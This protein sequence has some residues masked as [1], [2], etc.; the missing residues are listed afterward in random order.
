LL[1]LA[2]FGFLM[3]WLLIFLHPIMPHANIGFI[4]WAFGIGML[5]H[6]MMDTLTK[7][8]V[9]WLLPVPL[10][11]G[12]PPLRRLR[13]TTGKSVESFIVFPLLVLFNGLFYWAHYNQIL[14]ILHQHIQ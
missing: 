7:E 4:W 1:G 5:S 13:I 10:K 8:G 2:L 3:H 6:L 12:I 14:L 11:F 9:P